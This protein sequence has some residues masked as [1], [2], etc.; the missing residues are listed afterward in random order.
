LRDQDGRIAVVRAARGWFLPGGGIDPDEDERQA[1]ERETRE[2]CGLVIRLSGIIGHATE[3]VHSPA[4]HTGVDKESVFF[5]A[6]V[7]GATVATEPDHELVWLS[8]A[9]AVTR[10]SQKSHR[11][12][13]LRL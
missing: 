10:L 8:A 12:A 7:I 3:I 1:V 2:E 5:S 6:V 4:G 9:E 13:V 11:W